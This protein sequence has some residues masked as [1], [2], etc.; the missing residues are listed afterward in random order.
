MTS[1]HYS[2]PILKQGKQA[3]AVVTGSSS[4]FGLH[5]CIELARSGYLVVATMP[6]RSS[7]PACCKKRRHRA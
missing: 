5:T 3:V 4:G 1:P 2:E 7:P 6:I